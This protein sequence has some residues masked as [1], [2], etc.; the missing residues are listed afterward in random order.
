ME[1][2]SESRERNEDKKER[3]ETLAD[4]E[5]EVRRTIFYRSESSPGVS[6]KVASGAGSA[7]AL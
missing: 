1:E 7:L 4:G 6:V 2:G 5:A 3:E